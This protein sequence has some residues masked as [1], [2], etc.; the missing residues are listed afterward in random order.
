MNLVCLMDHILLQTFKII[1]RTFLKKHETIT[2]N[3]PVQIYTNKI[4]DKI[5]FKIKT[6]YRLELL[7]SE[8]IKLLGNTKKDVDQ[9]KVGEVVPK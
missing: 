4:R 2:D 6:D 5:V 3:L 1:L 7:S 9:N 8:K